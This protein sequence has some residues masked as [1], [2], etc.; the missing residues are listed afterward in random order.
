MKRDEVFLTSILACELQARKP[1][2]GEWDAR[3]EHQTKDRAGG[4]V[5]MLRME[6]A[7]GICGTPS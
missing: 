1:R 3:W 6:F 7:T 5:D 2:L 4:K